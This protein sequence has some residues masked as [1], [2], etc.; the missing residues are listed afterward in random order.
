MFFQRSNPKLAEPST[1]RFLCSARSLILYFFSSLKEDCPSTSSGTTVSSLAWLSWKFPVANLR[2]VFTRGF[3]NSSYSDQDRT[4]KALSALSA[5]LRFLARGWRTTGKNVD[6]KKERR[7]KSCFSHIT[8][9]SRG[10]G[11]H[12]AQCIPRGSA[13]A[14]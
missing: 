7:L 10:A 8:M 14:T 1:K 3:E 13:L 5:R 11:E 2:N 9:R 6:K 12:G 4:L